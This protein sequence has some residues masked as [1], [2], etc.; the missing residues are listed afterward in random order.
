MGVLPAFHRFGELQTELRLRIWVYAAWSPR[1]LFTREVARCSCT[2]CQESRDE[3]LKSYSAC[4][5]VVF[6]SP[7][8]MRLWVK[9]YI[10]PNYDISIFLRAHKRRY[11]TWER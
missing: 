6:S 3:A 11:K 1:V 8:D 10:F 9:D 5:R 4:I 7:K 2:T